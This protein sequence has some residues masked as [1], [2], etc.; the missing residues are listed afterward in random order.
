MSEAVWETVRGNWR[1]SV[2]ADGDIAVM[3]LLLGSDTVANLSASPARG[4]VP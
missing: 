1:L 2:V 3:S 4:T